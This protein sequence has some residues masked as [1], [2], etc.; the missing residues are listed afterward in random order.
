MIKIITLIFLISFLLMPTILVAQESNIMDALKEAAGSEGA[1]YDTTVNQETAF[2]QAM[3][4]VVRAFISLLGIIFISYTI[5]GGFLWMTAAGN[6]EK[7]GEAKKIIKNGVIGLIIIFASAAIYVFIS[8][9]LIG[10]SGPLP[11]GGSDI[12]N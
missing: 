1:G 6:D 12:R 10:N 8:T 5:Y 3:G 2:A 9:A 11:S 4:T 7:V